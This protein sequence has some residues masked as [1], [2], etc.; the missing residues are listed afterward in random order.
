[1]KKHYNDF[2]KYRHLLYELVSSEIK[3]KYR[4][5]F[6]GVFWSVLQPLGMMI[7]LTIVFSTM[8]KSDIEHFPVY[9]LTGR[10]IWDLLSLSTNFALGSIVTNAPLIKKV[11]LP[12]YIFPV[13]KSLSALVN[14]SFSMVALLIVVAISD[15][16]V[17]YT[18]LFIP[19]PLILLYLFTVGVGLI[20]SSLTVFFRD[21]AHLYE[22]ILTAWM[23][24]TPI[25]YPADILPAPV[26]KL[27][28]LNPVY[29]YLVMFRDL[30]M[31]GQMP[32]AETWVICISMAALSLVVGFFVF[33]KTEDKFILHI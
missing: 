22:L 10:I 5:S 7:I 9:V 23:Y 31:Y 8:F 24:L 6:L 21:L 16:D 13:S 15:I 2:M 20:V 30:V 17:T 32:T 12:K 14:C 26:M 1:M 33:S 18:I 4:R 29:H 28:Q 19:I 25:F 27:M 11:Y 3:V